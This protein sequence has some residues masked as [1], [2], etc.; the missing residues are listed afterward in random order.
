MFKL[1]ISLLWNRAKKKDW[2]TQIGAYLLRKGCGF[3]LGKVTNERK[4]SAKRFAIERVVGL[5]YHFGTKRIQPLYESKN[6]RLK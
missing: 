5:T 2:Q 3:E 6:V 4:V 1:I